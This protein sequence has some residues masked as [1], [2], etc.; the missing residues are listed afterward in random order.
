MVLDDYILF[1]GN[2]LPYVNSGL[3]II[4]IN[5][6]LMRFDLRISLSEYRKKPIESL[7]L[8]I[9]LVFLSSWLSSSAQTRLSRLDQGFV[10]LILFIG[11]ILLVFVRRERKK[12]RQ[13]CVHIFQYLSL[14][15]CMHRMDVKLARVF[16]SMTS[17]LDVAQYQR[18]RFEQRT[19]ATFW[20]QLQVQHVLL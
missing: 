19:T 10:F 4:D 15:A 11:Y 16:V 20:V 5:I 9:F 8:G 1:L 17:L 12:K 2:M 14:C 18:Q 6:L 3:I 7:I 13:A